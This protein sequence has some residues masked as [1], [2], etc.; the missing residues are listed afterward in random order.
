MSLLWWTKHDMTAVQNKCV[1]CK[2]TQSEIQIK[3]ANILINKRFAQLKIWP[4]VK[5][6]HINATVIGWVPWCCR[7]SQHKFYYSAY[8]STTKP[9]S[10]LS[11]TR[12]HLFLPLTAWLP[13]E[14]ETSFLKPS[15]PSYILSENFVVSDG[16]ND[17]HLS[18]G[19]FCANR[20]NEYIKLKS[21]RLQ[22]NPA[23][24]TWQN[25]RTVN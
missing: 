3:T 1:I 6:L 25:S 22:T 7:I 23:P 16:N 24:H 21:R 10:S 11:G 13:C 2:S 9:S 18:I 19:N 5:L 14:N 17:K 15:W 4:F 12:R 20:G 8:R